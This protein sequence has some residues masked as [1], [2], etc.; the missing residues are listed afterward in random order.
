MNPPSPKPEGDAKTT[1]GAAPAASSSPPKP[2]GSAPGKF[3]GRG[4]SSS[5][6]KAGPPVAPPP[7]F[8]RID[9]LTMAVT[10]ILIFAGYVLTMAPDVTLEDSGELATGSFYAGVPHPPGYPVWTL[11]TWL[12]TVLVPFRNPAWRVGLGSCVAGSLACGFLALIVSRGS[13]MIIEG[14]AAF[15]E[16]NKLAEGAICVV[17][18]FVAGL[19]MGF[20]GYMWSQSV[21]V[22]VYTLSVLSLMGVLGCLLR[23]MYAPG[24]KLYLYIALFLFGICLTNHMS[25]LVAAMGIQVAILCVQPKLGRDMFFVNTVIFL[26]GLAMKQYHIITNFDNN[27]QIYFLFIVIGL[28]SIVGLLW[29]VIATNGFGSELLTVVIMA[30]M[31]CLGAAFYFYMPIASMTNPPMNWGY[32]RTVDGFKHAVERGQ[33]ESVHPTPNIKKYVQQ[34]GIYADGGIDEFGRVYLAIGLLPFVYFRF[35]QKREKAWIMGLGAI[36]SCLAFLLLY[37]L[38]PGS[39]RQSLSLNKVFFTASYVIVSMG[40]G[41]GIALISATLATQ[42][43]KTRVYFLVGAAVALGMAV[44]G[45]KDTI[46]KAFTDV[47]M[48][49]FSLLR[50]G[51]MH[52]IVEKE[53]QLQIF[54]ELFLVGLV[55]A[56]LALFVVFRSRV[57]LYAA[58]G[59]FALMPVHSIVGHWS[60]NE[61]RG[62]LF[63]FWF[64]HDMFTPPFNIYPEM[65]RDAVLFGG[66]D[67]GRFCPTYMI[68]CESFVPPEKRTEDPKFDR[69]D[70]YLITQN[71]LADVTYLNYIRAHY[72]RSAQ[73]DPPFFQTL[74]GKPFAF[75]DNIFT[76]IGKK[77]EARRRAEGVYPMTEIHTPG[78]DESDRAFH[79]YITDAQDRFRNGQMR[80]GEDFHPDENGMIQVQ[81]QVAVMMINGLLAKDIFDANPNHEFYVEESFPL[82]WMYPYETPFG[83]IMKINRQPLPELTQDIVD[84]DHKFWSLY[85]KR[86][87]GDW[88]TYD[89]PI[90]NVCAF[91]EKLYLR[92]DFRGFT[93]DPKFIRDDDAQKAFSKLRSSQ[94]GLYAWRVQNAKNPAE[95]ARMYTEALF[96]FKQSFAY[97]PYSP[98]AVYH[99]VMLL[100]NK[101]QF[102]DAVSVASTCLKLDPGNGQI[103][104]LLDELRNMKKSARATDI[105]GAMA[106]AN[107]LFAKGQTNAAVVVIDQI[108]ASPVAD[109]QAL[110]E[111]A[112]VY[113]QLG[114]VAKLEL[115]LER[116]V[117]KVPENPEAWYDLAGLRA[118][119]GKADPSLDALEKCVR[120][121]NKRLVVNPTAKNLLKEALVDARFAALRPLP[122]FQQITQAK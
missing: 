29:L 72:N 40:I 20:N 49:G 114:N 74:L 54:S 92:R 52:A 8:R 43:E 99:F 68:F 85:S 122:R 48:N 83:I 107:S 61:Q 19:L 58:L 70:V 113:A 16:I 104:N 97:C 23:W 121:S 86:L 12:F 112:R 98:E 38:N 91:A 80:P 63:G 105:P 27:P 25:L 118:M 102:D 46:A 93:G 89:T 71:A 15:K 41:Y 69:R 56:V 79:D 115:T 42:Y 53:N 87:I 33:Y 96:A 57:P 1:K 119:M 13:S 34:I 103:A 90:S 3:A 116:I 7:L 82:D 36:Y 110:L 37:L 106:E 17:S 51:V 32:A 67:P 6:R 30:L 47:D 59:L 55:L 11:Y 28:L 81:G 14:I 95:Q 111:C 4:D 44:Y 100:V 64:G 60:D 45:L 78:H 88:L 2:P 21:I 101:A 5:A 94:G 84:K 22:E 24:Q 120:L 73:I 50:Y 66:T 117:Q 75:L 39:D 62:H 77:V 26:A 76:S 9:W 65:T 31:W 108:S 109:P 10:T 35:M 18:G